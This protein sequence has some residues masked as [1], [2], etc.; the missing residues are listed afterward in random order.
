MA[1][2]GFF[3]RA[4]PSTI[5]LAWNSLGCVLTLYGNGSWKELHIEEQTATKN[6]IKVTSSAGSSSV[7]ITLRKVAG[8]TGR[9]DYSG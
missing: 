4:A 6:D 5:I 9:T 8:F 1:A 3:E 7:M 2:I